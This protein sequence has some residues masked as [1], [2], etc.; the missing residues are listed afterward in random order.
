MIE[1]MNKFA[2]IKTCHHPHSLN[3][4]QIYVVSASVVE[5]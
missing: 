1:S 2:N 5:R 3:T 4:R